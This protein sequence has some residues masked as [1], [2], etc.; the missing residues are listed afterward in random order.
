MG[1]IRIFFKLSS[2]K[3]YSNIDIHQFLTWK[4]HNIDNVVAAVKRVAKQ[5]FIQ[6]LTILDELMKVIFTIMLESNDQNLI[7]QTYS[8]LVGVL[9]EANKN[10]N[11][12][13]KP[14]I[15]EWIELHFK[16]SKVWRTLSVQQSRLL[17]WIASAEAIRAQSKD[18]GT[19]LKQRSAE[20]IRQLQHSMRGVKYLFN[21]MKRSCLLEI[22][23]ADTK[24]NKNKI[25]NEYNRQITALFLS[26]NRVMGLK[27]PKTVAG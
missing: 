24:E 8:T 16:Y 14:R 12:K 26:M 22:D 7:E 17:Q 27:Q 11:S 19:D 1:S 13:Y 25:T 2:T 6:L 3:I 10:I 23:E 20:M 15:K 21:I 5:P 4:N 18:A 9:G